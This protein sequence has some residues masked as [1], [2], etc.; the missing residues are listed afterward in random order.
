MSRWARTAVGERSL[1][2]RSVGRGLSWIEEKL[3]LGQ[4]RRGRGGGGKKEQSTCGHGSRR[5][6]SLGFIA[7]GEYSEL[8]G[9]AGCQGVELV[10]VA[11]RQ[12]AKLDS[13][14]LGDKQ[15]SRRPAPS[16]KPKAPHTKKKSVVGHQTGKRPVP[17]GV[18]PGMSMRVGN[19]I[20]GGYNLQ[21]KG[22]HGDTC[23]RAR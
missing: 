11:G 3:E 6:C 2:R 5:P 17:F 10:G 8:V 21:P 23:L 13:V 7:G 15:K 22:T 4:H 9:V 18:G 1:G 16:S 12:G 20:I 14:V 19:K